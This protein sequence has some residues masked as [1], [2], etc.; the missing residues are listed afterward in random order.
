MSTLVQITP[1]IAASNCSRRG[2]HVT[3]KAESGLAL[4]AN[5]GRSQPFG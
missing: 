3:G 2:A 4:G 5:V 1:L